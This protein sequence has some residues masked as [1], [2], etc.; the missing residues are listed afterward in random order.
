MRMSGYRSNLRRLGIE[1][2][3]FPQ[4]DYEL[5]LKTLIDQRGIELVVDVGA[6]TGQFG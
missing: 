3:R 2:R 6:N 5:T 4:R 1:L